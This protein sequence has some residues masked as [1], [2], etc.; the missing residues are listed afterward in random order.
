MSDLKELQRVAKEKNEALLVIQS[1][2]CQMELELQAEVDKKV[3]EKFGET[4]NKALIEFNEASKALKMEEEKIAVE[5]SLGKIPFPIGTKMV[6]WERVRFGDGW[7]TPCVFGTLEVFKKGDEYPR[8]MRWNAPNPGDVI[9]RI[10]TK[11]GKPS[12]KFDQYR[13]CPNIAWVPE[14]SRPREIK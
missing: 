11:D 4:E 10:L 12:K 6:R 5:K 1:Q 8:N 13:V 3:R 9:V 2:R 7:R 14:G